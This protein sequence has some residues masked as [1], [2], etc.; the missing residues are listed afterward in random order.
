MNFVKKC[1]CFFEDTSPSG[2]EVA[3]A[4]LVLRIAIAIFFI[5]HGYGK[6]FGTAPGLEGFTGMLAG[7][8]FPAAGAMALLV[9]VAEFFGG[10]AL[11][12]G[13]F[14]RFSAFWL[15]LISLVAWITVKGFG[16][17][18]G[19]LDLLSLGGTLALL[20]AGPGMYSVSKYLKK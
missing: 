18:A 10:I 6:L 3:W 19:D 5:T 14:T 17:P 13:V 4:L 8:G 12:L 1:L 2:K 11:L 15:A 7:L 20:F 16:L 9:G